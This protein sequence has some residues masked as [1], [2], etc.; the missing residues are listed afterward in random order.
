MNL[1][2]YERYLDLHRNKS[3]LNQKGFLAATAA[4]FIEMSSYCQRCS[5][6][7]PLFPLF[8][9][10]HPYHRHLFLLSAFGHCLAEPISDIIN[11][12]KQVAICSNKSMQ[13]IGFLSS[14]NV[15]YQERVCECVILCTQSARRESS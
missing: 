2:I 1:N 13:F 12:K 3:D 4:I 8:S 9:S 11:I 14:Q 5:V 15:I 7:F 6:L 10:S